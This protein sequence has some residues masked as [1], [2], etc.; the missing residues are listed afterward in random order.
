MIDRRLH[1][2]TL[3]TKGKCCC[4]FVVCLQEG[5]LE[6]EEIKNMLVGMKIKTGTL[7]LAC[8][9]WHDSIVCW[10]MQ[11][12]VRCLLLTRIQLARPKGMPPAC[13]AMLTPTLFFIVFV[14]DLPQ[15]TK[16]I[17][18]ACPLCPL[19][20]E[21]NPCAHILWYALCRFLSCSR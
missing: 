13:T 2:T 15:V 14:V 16:Y 7:G 21:H 6:M 8:A 17:Y 20:C 1:R 5:C 18:S 10:E 9:H 12:V 4:C 3:K 19:L 11:S